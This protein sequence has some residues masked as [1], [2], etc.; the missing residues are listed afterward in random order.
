MVMLLIDDCK[1]AILES[2]KTI[3]KAKYALERLK[4]GLDVQRVK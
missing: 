2:T 4:R 3:S 1:G